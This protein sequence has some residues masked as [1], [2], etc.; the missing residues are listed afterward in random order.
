MYSVEATIYFD[1]SSNNFFPPTNNLLMLATLIPADFPSIAKMFPIYAFL[2]LIYFLSA[3]YVKAVVEPVP[4]AV[5]IISMKSV[6][7]YKDRFIER[8]T[9]VISK[10]KY[11]IQ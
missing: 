7:S 6:T 1:H 8:L 10:I 9:L 5:S 4:K 2:F 11:K 3:A